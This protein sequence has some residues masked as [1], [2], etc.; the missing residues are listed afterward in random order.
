MRRVIIV[1]RWEGG[2]HDD[3]R[4]WLKSGLEKIGYEVFVPDMPDTNTPVVEKWV[5]KIKEVVG[6][7][8][9]DTYFVGHSIGCQAILRYLQTIDTPVGGAVFV[10]GW[11]NLDNLESSE[12]KEIA[13]PWIETSIDFDKLR[14]VL[15]R[16]TLL[17]SDNDP[18][19]CF[20]ENKQKFGILKSEIKII[21]NG[22][23][24]TAEDGYSQFPQ[25]ISELKNIVIKQYFQ[26][27]TDRMFTALESF[28]LWKKM[29]ALMNVNEVGP[30]VAQK[31]VDIFR[32]HWDFFHPVMAGAYKMFIIDLSIF[33]DAEKYEDTFSLHKLVES[34]KENIS[35]TEYKDLLKK[36]KDIKQK[37]GPAI[38]LLLTL[39]NSDVAHQ[40]MEKK[41]RLIIYKEIEDLFVGVQEILNLL[42]KYFNGAFTV[43]DHV[44]KNVEHGTEW[45]MENLERGEKDRLK[46]I[47]EK[48]KVDLG[49]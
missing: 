41:K 13:K 45:V 26:I 39:R 24:L 9:G 14:T 31:N 20:E 35:E 17:I 36:I 25:V 48:Y 40:K 22:G 11:F 21:N 3:W 10:A 29:N 23:H 4:P 1:H 27:T 42:S 5:S 47:E 8:D 34:I 6:E 37:H 49:A 30:E 12:V 2:S 43:W 44:G 7:P 38:N 32:K 33:F 46:E 19:S 28:H 16:S 18:Y 15:H